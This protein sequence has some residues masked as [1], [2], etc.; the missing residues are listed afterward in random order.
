[1]VDGDV[2]SAEAVTHTRVAET[3][4][5]GT[6]IIK[7]VLESLD[8]SPS[9]PRAESLQTTTTHAMDEQHDYE[10]MANDSRPH[11][12]RPSKCRVSAIMADV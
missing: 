9:I 7:H 2:D 3:Q 11:T 5:D 6:T 10:Q 1:M 12:P 4:I 8:S